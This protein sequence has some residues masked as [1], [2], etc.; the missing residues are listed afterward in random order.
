MAAIWVGGKS[1][2]KGI[3]RVAR[4]EGGREGGRSGGNREGVERAK[5]WNGNN[6]ALFLLFFNFQFP[7]L[8]ERGGTCELI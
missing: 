6:G 4:R 5:E 7:F 1:K 3:G 2:G 8:W